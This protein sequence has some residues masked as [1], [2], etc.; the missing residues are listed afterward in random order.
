[1]Y[2]MVLAEELIAYV[3][4]SLGHRCPV[5]GCGYFLTPDSFQDGCN[6]ML[7]HGFKCLHVGQETTHGPNGD[8]WHSTVAVFGK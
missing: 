5:S 8:L 2:N 4:S 6:H 1:M 7:N 3:S